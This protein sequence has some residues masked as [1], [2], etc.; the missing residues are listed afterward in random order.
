MYFSFEVLFVLDEKSR[1]RI[2]I[3]TR[4]YIRIF[5]RSG[6]NS[7]DLKRF[8]FFFG[9]EAY[10]ALVLLIMKYFLK[11]MKIDLKKE[12]LSSAI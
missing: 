6:A 8:F 1:K 7:T 2:D 12:L 4:V 11:Q 3:Y 5:F 9:V 10:R